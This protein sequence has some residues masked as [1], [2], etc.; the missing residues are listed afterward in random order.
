MKKT[1]KIFLIVSKIVAIVAIVAYGL[2]FTILEIIGLILTVS[3]S[4]GDLGVD[5]QAA[6]AVVG[7]TCLG[8]GI[9][10]LVGVALSIVGLV[11]INIGTKGLKNAKCHDEIVKPAVLTIIAG[12]LVTAF[13][14]P[15]GILM[16]CLK[17]SDF[18]NN[19]ESENVVVDGE[20]IG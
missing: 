6:L 7:G 3:S 13:G 10:M 2:A 14:I 17:P 20:V 9:G 19:V 12:G 18:E 15:A 16:L 4:T 1:S 11:F 5:E 8:T